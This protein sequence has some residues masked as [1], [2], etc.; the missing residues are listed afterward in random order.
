LGGLIFPVANVVPFNAAGTVQVKDAGTD[1]GGP[2]P[3][4][5]GFAFGSFMFLP[6][7]QYSLS[8]VFTPADSTV[9]QSATSNT[10]TFRL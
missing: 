9:W 6:P 3:V 7:G 1:L 2:V 8:E 10:V 5:S 4:I